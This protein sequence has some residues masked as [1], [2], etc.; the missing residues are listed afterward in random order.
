MASFIIVGS[1]LRCGDEGW[2]WVRRWPAPP[3]RHA[4]SVLGRVSLGKR[5][6]T[7]CSVFA[8]F[9]PLVANLT[10]I[11][12][13]A[14]YYQNMPETT[15]LAKEARS[16]AAISLRTT[17]WCWRARNEDGTYEKSTRR[18]TWPATAGY[19]S[20]QFGNSTSRRR[21]TTR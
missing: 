3:P 13:Q 1:P 5:L 10:L 6:N 9:A 14:D 19:S 17:A 8:L 15:A 21:T 2:A 12:V 18:A 20:P 11:M 4:N 7:A 16:S